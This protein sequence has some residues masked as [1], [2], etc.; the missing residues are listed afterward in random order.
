[1]VYEA[2]AQ[3]IHISDE[4]VNVAIQNQLPPGFFAD[5]K[6]VKKAE[7]ESALSQQNMTV[8]DLKDDIERQ[9]LVARLRDIALEGTVVSPKEVEAEYRKRNEKA[10][11]EY[12]ILTPAKFASEVKIDDAAMRDYY[13]KNKQQFQI[14][15]KKS[16]AYMVFDPATLESSI[17]MTDD[18]V[19]REY[20]A[21]L[22]KYRVPERAQARHI[23]LMTHADKNDDAAVKAKAEGL[24][25]QIKSGGDFAAIAKANSQDP[26][27]A[28][29]GGNLDWVTRG[30]MVKPFEDAVFTLKPN[31]ISD[32]VKTQYGYHIVQVT[33]KEPAHLRTFEE[34]KPEIEKSYRKTRMNDFMVK[35]GEKADAALRK[36]PS[37]PEKA[38]AEVGQQ[39]CSMPITL[40]PASRCRCSV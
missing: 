7:L 28:A 38:A 25:K 21:N 36:D 1:M 12:V 16:I 8:A 26:G 35:L 14:P 3:G 27:S 40:F 32:L 20:N 30:Q 33:A 10:K 17:P 11:I 22:D 29:K 13:A 9:M 34:V 15:A 18:D 31:E 19:H 2:K 4:D 6:L 5:G 39:L 37:H 23:L 24:L